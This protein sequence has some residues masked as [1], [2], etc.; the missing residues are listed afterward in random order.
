MRKLLALTVAALMA[1]P[2]LADS[3]TTGSFTYLTTSETT[4]EITA[5]SLE[6]GEAVI[7]ETVTDEGTGKTY[8][9][10]SIGEGVF[11]WKGITSVTMPNSIKTIGNDAFK[12]CT[13]MTKAQLSENLETIGA[14]AFQT[15]RN[16]TEINWPASLKNIKTQAFWNSMG[17]TGQIWLPKGV[18]VDD[19]AFDNMT[20]A[21][22]LWLDG[23]PGS[24]G[25]KQ[26]VGCA[27]LKEF[28]LN[29]TY[30]PLFD[31]S[32][33]FYTDEWSWD[34]PT[35]I[36]LYVPVGA[37]E[38]YTADE[39]WTA[40]FTTIEEY[41]FTNP[42]TTNPGGDDPG[43]DREYETYT[44]RWSED[45]SVAYLNV[46]EAGKLP[47]LTAGH[48]DTLKEIHLSGKLNGDDILLLRRMSGSEQDGSII[49]GAILETIDLTNC[50]IVPGGEPY[51][52]YK[53]TCYT[54]QDAVGMNM[55][56]N[57]YSLKSFSMPKYA[58]SIGNNAFDGAEN[59]TAFH[60]NATVQSIG[61]L[62]FCNCKAI[63][64][65]ELPD[66][67]STF[68]DM[69]FYICSSLKNV[70][71]PSSLTTIPFA[72][73]YFCG[74]LPEVALPAGVKSIDNLAFHNCKSLTT[75]NIPAATYKISSTAFGYCEKL[76]ALNVDEANTDFCDKDGVLFNKNGSRLILYP[77]G[78]RRT[79][80]DAK[81]VV[82]IRTAD[83]RTVKTI[84]R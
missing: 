68:G 44:D 69:V 5:K 59:M 81:G 54:E 58:A 77:V 61:E 38:N 82:I 3:F 32:Q 83:G 26:F 51:Y 41:D 8:T 67:C 33:T 13:Q 6:D 66:V 48:T 78:K 80:D 25:M 76:S 45:F 11:V 21:T 73:F 9:V 27:Q 60:C 28:Y 1:L 23:Q 39:K 63:E 79:G 17:Y 65:I 36:T 34:G 71:L 2:A 53:V 22:S 72:T 47:R 52:S 20:K 18:N 7:P 50:E 57:C 19:N 4:V 15:T 12:F 49:E 75:V 74:S 40:R 70:H 29:C 55:F 31:P 64:N 35:E 16:I 42:D 46:Y 10:T 56:L 43:S 84:R 30:P 37:K 14:N 62:A 24:W